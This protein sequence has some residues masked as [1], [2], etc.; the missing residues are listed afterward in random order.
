MQ[1]NPGFQ[2]KASKQQH[3]TSVQCFNV[4]VFCKLQVALLVVM[5]QI[6]C[7]VPATF[8]SFRCVGSV[9]A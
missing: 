9:S 8:M 2:V 1:S 5:A 7:Y 4:V 6:G 3:Y